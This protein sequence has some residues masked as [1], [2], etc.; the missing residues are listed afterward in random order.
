ML[1]NKKEGV[2]QCGP[3]RDETGSRRPT[4]HLCH[5]YR[6]AASATTTVTYWFPQN[7]SFPLGRR[8]WPL[9]KCEWR[10]PHDDGGP[11]VATFFVCVSFGQRSLSLM[12]FCLM[13]S[14]QA[15]AGHS[16][17]N[18]P[19]HRGRATLKSV[20]SVSRRPSP[21]FQSVHCS[22]S[23]N[24][25]LAST[26]NTASGPSYVYGHGS[27]SS[28]VQYTVDD[29]KLTRSSSGYFQPRR[30]GPERKGMDQHERRAPSEETEEPLH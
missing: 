21:F 10:W 6:G 12:F 18:E 4:A 7:P 22:S 25:K 19:P 26:A 20:S 2:G 5:K 11:T 24:A 23:S 27:A 3:A 15:S 30:R 13:V 8:P 9:L 14:R 16:A 28:S 29:Q 17:V 1:K